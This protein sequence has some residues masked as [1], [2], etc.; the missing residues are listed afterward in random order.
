MAVAFFLLTFEGFIDFFTSKRE[1]L[2]KKNFTLAQLY[3]RLLRLT[4]GRQT[5]SGG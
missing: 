1:E 3:G 4:Y 5:A 2:N